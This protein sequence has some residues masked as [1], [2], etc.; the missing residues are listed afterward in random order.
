MRNRAG[1]DFSPHECFLSWMRCL[2][3]WQDGR[4]VKEKTACEEKL[5]TRCSLTAA[6]LFALLELISKT[7]IK[8]NFS[9]PLK[10]VHGNCPRQL[11][12]TKLDRWPLWHESLQELQDCAKHIRTR[13]NHATRENYTPLLPAKVRVQLCV[14]QFSQNKMTRHWREGR[15]WME[16]ARAWAAVCS[17]DE[18]LRRGWSDFRKLQDRGSRS[19]EVIYPQ[20]RSPQPTP[21]TDNIHSPTESTTAEDRAVSEPITR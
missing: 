17:Q 9:P 10:T 6:C 2:Q 11:S 16:R 5:Q 4:M 13:L 12:K 14:F 18:V 20:R 8:P 7:R 1:E 19:Q 21:T 3:E 15:A